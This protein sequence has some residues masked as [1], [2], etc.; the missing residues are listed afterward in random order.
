MTQTNRFRP[1]LLTAVLLLIAGTVL[2]AAFITVIANR[3]LA[4]GLGTPDYMEGNTP[5]IMVRNAYL[6]HQHGD[7]AM[8][9]TLY[10]AETWAEMEEYDRIWYNA[11]GQSQFR[12]LRVIGLT[13]ETDGAG[14]VHLAIYNN[15][16]SYDSF[17]HLRTVVINEIQVHVAQIDG[18]WKLTQ[19][20]RF[21][22]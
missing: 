2:A 11:Y 5:E 12:G 4:P 22:W 19:P 9:E 3:H 16:S 13:E 8:L 7:E 17:L 6:A 18:V 1:D 15:Q 14:T 20:L 10:T 21:P